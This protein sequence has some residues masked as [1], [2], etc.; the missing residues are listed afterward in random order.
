MGD[1][2]GFR[3]F[4]HSNLLWLDVVEVYRL[5]ALSTASTLQP[6]GFEEGLRLAVHSASDWTG[7]FQKHWWPERSVDVGNK[8]NTLH[9]GECKD[10]NHIGSE[11]ISKTNIHI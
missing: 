5:I 7:C 4:H 10:V 9:E 1:G 3:L 6:D 2:C 8:T 11:Y